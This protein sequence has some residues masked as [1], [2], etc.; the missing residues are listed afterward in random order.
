MTLLSHLPHVPKEVAN[1]LG[2]T[3][4]DVIDHYLKGEPADAQVDAGRFCEAALRYLEWKMGGKYTAVDGKSKP[5][6]KTVVNAARQNTRLDPTLR[7]QVPQAL[8]LIMD[9]RNNRNS[10]HLGSIDANT[11]DASCVVQNVTWV[12]GELARIE[13]KQ[14]VQS[15]QTL[16]DRLAKRHVP[17]IQM[18]GDTPV[19]LHPALTAAQRALVLLYQQGEPVPIQTLRGWAEY[20]NST[21]WRR[22]VIAPLQRDKLV[23]LDKDERVHLLRPGED[24]AQKILLESTRSAV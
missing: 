16:L 2:D 17:S 22:D 20:K 7:A 1:A 19:I 24:E 3:Y 23:H 8:E 13:S 5:N 6:R 11:M 18:I 21:Q 14:D 12:M 9:F 15:I 10:A 4:R